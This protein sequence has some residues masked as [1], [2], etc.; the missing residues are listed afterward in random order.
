[1]TTFF[2]VSGTPPQYEISS[3]VPASG[4]VLKA[5]A[6]GTS[7]PINMATD[8]TGGTLVST[9]TLNASG[10]PAVSGNVIIPHIAQNY[11]LALYPSA[12]AAASNTGAIW[13]LDNVQIGTSG[14]SQGGLTDIA[15][16]ATVSLNSDSTN[17]FNMTGTTTITGITLAEGSVATVKFAG[18]LILTN[19]A[20]LINIG[21]SNITT[22]VGD[23]AVF[24]GETGGVVRM[25]SYIRA[26]SLYA[27]TDSPTFT[28]TPAAPTAA[29]RTNTTQLATTAYVQGEKYLYQNASLITSSLATGTTTI[30]LDDT[31][32]QNTEGDEYM[33]LAF[34]PISASSTLVIEATVI[35][36]S[37]GGGHAIAALF[38]N[39]DANA[40]A[41][42]AQISG[43]VGT[44]ATVKMTYTMTAGT[45][46]AI[47]FRIR[48]GHSVAG[49]T[50][51]NGVSGARIF[52]GVAKS[53]ITIREVR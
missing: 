48:G 25:Q 44:A 22:A 11:K 2:A 15:S 9:I 40:L 10:Y 8:Y 45:T 27:A 21:G 16:D 37:G 38:K 33:T 1:M 23:I 26:A 4:Y 30:P 50:S 52:G 5:Y 31:I 6:A 20:F 32:P 28:G 42:G 13:T 49:T 34:T 41:A 53:S 18:V 43:G 36:G 24:R 3:G 29:V 17:Y 14:D 47:T 7:T 19:S 39:S 51:F 12:S 46:S 35:L